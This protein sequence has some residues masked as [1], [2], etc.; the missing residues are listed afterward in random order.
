MQGDKLYVCVFAGPP[1]PP[2]ST[3]GRG[4]VC[5][6]NWCNV[7]SVVTFNFSNT[8]SHFNVNREDFLEKGALED[9]TD[10]RE[11]EVNRE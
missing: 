7:G 4:E 8:Q 11:A 5:L 3:G 10:R 2:G 9:Q 6:I 1:G